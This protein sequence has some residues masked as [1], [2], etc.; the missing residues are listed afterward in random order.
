MNIIKLFDNKF[1]LRNKFMDD[2]EKLKGVSTVSFTTRRIKTAD[3]DYRYMLT[4]RDA[5]N[6]LEGMKIHKVLVHKNTRLEPEMKELLSRR[7]SIT[8][9][10][11]VSMS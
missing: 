10:V 8:G 6:R 5:V 11:C 4:G 1:L 7:L 9:G 2:A 3:L